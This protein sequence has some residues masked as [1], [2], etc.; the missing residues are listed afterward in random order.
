[1][2]SGADESNSFVCERRERREKAQNTEG[3]A[4][5]D[6]QSQSGIPCN[7]RHEEGKFFQD[8]S[9]DSRF[10]IFGAKN[11]SFP[12]MCAVSQGSESMCVSVG[13]HWVSSLVSLGLHV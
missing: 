8:S 12:P 7:Y 4:E 6:S 1:M 13:S 2:F 10:V 9:C 3:M 11:T 5:T